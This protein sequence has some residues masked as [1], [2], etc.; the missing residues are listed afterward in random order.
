MVF[1]GSRER[2]AELVPPQLLWVLLFFISIAL[3]SAMMAPSAPPLLLLSLIEHLPFVCPCCFHCGFTLFS[4]LCCWTF[5]MTSETSVTLPSRSGEALLLLFW[6][7]DLPLSLLLTAPWVIPSAALVRLDSQSLLQPTVLSR[8]PSERVIL[9]N[10]QDN[11]STKVLYA[12]TFFSGYSHQEQAAVKD[13][14]IY[15]PAAGSQCV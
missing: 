13:K 4:P 1:T 14:L 8:F 15:T 12:L 3:S 10:K 2:G 11:F 5:V 7:E 9:Q 6:R